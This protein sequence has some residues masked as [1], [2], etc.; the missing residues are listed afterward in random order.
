MWVPGTEKVGP[1]LRRDL[2]AGVIFFAN[3]VWPYQYENGE[4]L[5][6]THL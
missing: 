3:T 1:A 5:R 6:E 2:S 4:L